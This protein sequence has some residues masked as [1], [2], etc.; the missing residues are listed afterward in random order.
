M[1][2]TSSG[3]GLI[4]HNNGAVQ[5]WKS[6]WKLLLR[7]KVYL[8]AMGSY[9]SGLGTPNPSCVATIVIHRSIYLYGRRVSE[10]RVPVSKGLHSQEYIAFFRGASVLG[11]LQTPANEHKSTQGILRD[12]RINWVAAT[13][14]SSKL[15]FFGNNLVY[16]T[17]TLW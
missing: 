13:E 6:K 12:A 17:F 3:L 4:G 5:G 7:I 1:D 15:P 10:T 2:T 8:I 16:Y 14:L 11:N 9:F